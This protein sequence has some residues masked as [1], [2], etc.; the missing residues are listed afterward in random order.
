METFDC[1]EI[2]NC[3]SSLFLA[4]QDKVLTKDEILEKY[5]V[6]VGSRATNYGK[7]LTKHD[8]F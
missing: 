5:N 4:F 2:W 8:E 3:Y 1:Y 6:F 7:D